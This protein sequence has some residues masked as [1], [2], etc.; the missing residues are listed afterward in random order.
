MIILEH[1]NNEIKLVF[2]VRSYRVR[3]EGGTPFE[4]L[5]WL[6]TSTIEGIKLREGTVRAWADGA[7]IGQYTVVQ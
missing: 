4:V 6:E 7:L 2:A 3:Y 5:Y 1:D